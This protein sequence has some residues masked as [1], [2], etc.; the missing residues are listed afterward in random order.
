MLKYLDHYKTFVVAI[1]TVLTAI[2]LLATIVDLSYM[3]VQDFL[4]M[5]RPYKWS[6]AVFLP[7]VTQSQVYSHNSSATSSNKPNCS[8][9]SRE[10]SFKI[11]L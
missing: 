11:S 5:L 4:S 7:Y 6:P 8:T 3:L 1:I 9:G 2:V 10:G